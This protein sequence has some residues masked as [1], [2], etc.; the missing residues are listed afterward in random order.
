MSPAS[1]SPKRRRLIIVII[2]VVLALFC[3]AYFT[4]SE[5]DRY[6]AQLIAQGE[7]LDLDQLAPKRTGHEPDGDAPLLAAQQQITNGFSFSNW[8][9]EFE[10]TDKGLQRLEWSDPTG[11]TNAPN[12]T[13]AITEVN[14]RRSDFL[15]LLQLLQDPPK[16]KGSDYR[17]F[18]NYKNGD[19]QL[20]RQIAAYL[21]HGIV[22]SA[23]SRNASMAFTNLTTL[24]NLTQLHREEWTGTQS[25][26]VDL[27]KLTL[28]DLNYC[29]HLH[30][31]NERQ[32]AE[33]Q[34]RLSSI[35]LITNCLQSKIMGRAQRL[36]LF[37]SI[38]QDPQ[39]YLNRYFVP[40][41]SKELRVIYWRNFDLDNE[42]LSSLGRC[43]SVL[44]FSASK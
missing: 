24:L 21:H 26:R 27:T 40:Q 18:E 37:S 8:K 31:W 29:L 36:A 41:A 25:T 22:I 1:P 15:L 6:K 42:A 11:Y 34:D 12:W 30:F 10:H 13:N 28:E 20:R 5:L 4:P 3:W 7:I 16:E 2:S 38:R 39:A 14:Y 9:F 17:D 32:L 33:I 44:M 35:S 23:Y 43:S 19:Y